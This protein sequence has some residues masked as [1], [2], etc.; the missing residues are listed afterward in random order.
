MSN[1]S[2]FLALID[3]MSDSDNTKRTQAEQTCINAANSNPQTFI[4]TSIA[5]INNTG[6]TILQ[7]KM[8]VI[9][10]KK[11]L[12]SDDGSESIYKKLNA[13]EQ[14]GLRRELLVMIAN[15]QDEALKSL[16]AGLVGHLASN[17]LGDSQA[18]GAPE[19][20]WPELIPHLFDLYAVGNGQNAAAVFQI[21]DPVFAHA[22]AALK[23]WIPEFPKLFESTLTTG[24]EKVK[25]I[26]I[27]SFVTFVQSCKRKDLKHVKKIKVLLQNFI[28]ELVKAKEEE[29]LESAFSFMIDIAD[30]EPGFFKNEVDAW[31]QIAAQM[32]GLGEESDSVLKTQGIE[33]LLPIFESFPDLLSKDHKRLEAFM[34]IITANMLEIDDE[35]AEEWKNPPEGFNDEIEE[36]DDQQDIKFAISVV[37]QLFEVVGEKEML[38]FLTTYLNPFVG[39]TNWKHRNAAIMILSQ[40][41]EYIGENTEYLRNIVTFVCGATKDANPRVRY[42]CCHL[43]GQ[44]ADDLQIKFQEAFS[45]E[46]FTHVIPLLD[47][48]VPRVVAHA[49]A[50][51]TNFLENSTKDQVAPFLEVLYTKLFHWILNGSSFVK[52]AGF[53]A[54]SGLFEGVSELLLPQLQNI[55]TVVFAVIQKSEGNLLKVLKGNAIECGT[56]ICKYAPRDSIEVYSE[57]LIKEMIKVVKSDVSRDGFDPQKSFLLTGFQ[58]LAAAVP[59]R[60]LPYLNEIVSSLFEMIKHA[61]VESQANMTNAKT[62]ATEETELAL[63][64]ISSFIENLSEA[65][66]PYEQH[67]Y[68]LMISVIDNTLDDDVKISA[69]DVLSM[70]AKLYKNKPT[71]SNQAILRKTVE[72]LWALVEAEVSPLLITDMLYNLQKVLKYS[73]N[74]FTPAELEAFFEKSKAVI[75]KSF[76][77]KSEAHEDIDEDDEK[78]EVNRALEEAAEIEQ[79]VQLEVANFIGSI[80][81]SH[82]AISLPIFTRALN[83]LVA[84]AMALPHGIKFALFLM[85]DSINY[86]GAAIPEETIANFVKTFVANHANEDLNIKQSC[87]FGIGVAAVALGEKFQPYFEEAMKT[88]LAV[89]NAPVPEKAGT[90]EHY[91]VID[92]CISAQGKIIKSAWSQLTPDILS[93]CLQSWL[94]GLP[95]VH[96]HKEGVMNLEMLI[97]ILQTKPDA[98][99][100]TPENIAKVF[101]IFATVYQQKKISNAQIDANIKTL[102]LGFFNNDHIK[103]VVAA[104]N[105]KDNTKAF[106]TSITQP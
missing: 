97:Q 62:S 59:D 18:P 16:L 45:K 15:V 70:L 50:S 41:G 78:E 7:R 8:C 60:L 32:R 77:R 102:S 99:L 83:E 89:Q 96:D 10:L 47:D 38:N 20:R 75:S 91:N 56:I 67:I 85:C 63:N 2:M 72:K 103:S 34:N 39:S 81:R 3:G 51:L 29:T 76:Q 33:F 94:N 95:L 82:K 4:G 104:A 55:M 24:T 93:K 65:M 9:L 22:M 84:P 46:Y 12:Y 64:M 13:V 11:L 25:L 30:S 74:C 100:S 17:I 86:L 57:P 92:N 21:L 71:P 40:V 42:A 80:F 28:V 6:C 48:P 61:I 52:E 88:V 36:Q 79:D 66:I 98:I 44:F 87:I 58:R 31:I 14:E 105:L 23:Q 43:L 27:E 35:V 49:L 68:E 1:E 5:I 90:V 37:N 101:E 106:I 73:E 26:A 54:M 19:T 53:S 69:L